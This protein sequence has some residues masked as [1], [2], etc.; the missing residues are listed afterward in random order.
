MGRLGNCGH[1]WG[2]GKFSGHV[3]IYIVYF[4]MEGY[5]NQQ[6]YPYVYL[7][8]VQ[9]ISEIREEVGDLWVDYKAYHNLL[10]GPHSKPEAGLNLGNIMSFYIICN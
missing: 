3:F 4:F 5:G 1:T 6:T 8:H 7:R 10:I 2:C 9:G